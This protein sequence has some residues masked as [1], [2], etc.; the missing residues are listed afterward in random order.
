LICAVLATLCLALAPRQQT[1]PPNASV[2]PQT[3]PPEAKPGEKPQ[4][5]AEVRFEGN[6]R[7][8]EETLRLQIRTRA[9]GPYT[10][11]TVD[12]DLRLLASR[13]LMAAAARLE[14]LPDG[15]LRVVFTVKEIP[16]V[17]RIEFDGNHHVDEDDLRTALGLS[18]NNVPPAMPESGGLTLMVRKLEEK[19]QDEGYLYVEIS[20]EFV[21]RGDE[22][23]LVFHILEGPEVSV[24]HVDFIGLKDFAPRHVRSVMKTSR[25][26]WFFTQ[27][28]KPH[29]L[30]D[31]VVQIESFLRDEGY[32][33]ARVGVDAVTPSADGED[34]D[35]LIRI[36]QGERY[37]VHSVKFDGNKNF[38][39][40]ELRALI[41][42]KPGE[43][44]RQTVYRKD[45]E[46]LRKQYRHLGY[47]EV[48]IPQRAV[49][50]YVG[51]KPEVDVIFRI[52]EGDPKR[53]RDVRVV[54]NTK[55]KDEVV[56]R[57]LDLYP[58]D[59]F[60]GDEML[61]AEDRLR[62]TGFFADERGQP[63]AW[64]ENE[65]TDDPKTEDVQMRVEDGT[66]GVFSLYG[67]VSS[68]NG[69]F[70]GTD[71]SIE[72]FDLFDLPSSPGALLPE[73]L[74]QRAFHGAGQ[75]LHLRANP[76]STYSNYLI[77]FI[78]PY[79][80]GPIERPVF[81][82]TNF[83][84][85]EFDPRHYHEKTVGA[86]VS[87]GK[88]L[89]RETSV[90]MGV[91]NDRI[92]IS[93]VD[94][95][96]DLLDV[97]GGNS[98]RGLVGEYHWTRFDSLRNTTQGMRLGVNGEWLGGPFGAQYDLLKFSTSGELF[99]PVYENEEEQR[100]VLWFRGAFALADPYSRTDETPIF[101]RYF[102]G[103]PGSF[104]QL[105]GFESRGVGPHDGSLQEGGSAGWVVNTEYVF[106]LIETYDARL[107]E[108]T[109][110][111]RGV[112]FAD[113]GMLESDWNSL[114]DGKWRLSVGAGLRLKIPF[115]LLSAPLELYYGVPLQKS[116]EDERQSF[117][118]N[119]STRF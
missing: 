10:A 60:D 100:H 24:D 36:D 93:N 23:V 92:T 63:L 111:L 114:M 109:P 99:V 79:L 73:F 7:I 78:E 26:F 58:G 102:A 115:Q 98:V 55:T 20:P 1:A 3:P 113:Q 38:S 41:K 105:R 64:V 106:P 67:G 8:P 17:R 11:E 13:F 88:R 42:M 65:K 108:S 66:N 62:A 69:V 37:T 57:E 43:P 81:L 29:E 50:S 52:T 110:F 72:N 31:D 70:V 101:E 9:G 35:I 96:E 103:G 6:T 85:I 33:D 5:L 14:R 84:I 94:P 34:V 22:Y 77:D 21:R 44:Y 76:G 46:R 112:I 107:R 15:S 49:E 53:V 82:D 51:N 87:V 4:I 18:Q 19:Y 61:A 95:F 16:S 54:G 97:E 104:L 119:F 12:S 28:Y 90:S 48:E 27:T 68:G 47:I 25:S 116:N 30:E 89:S 86:I 71:L 39:E 91:R 2:A 32:L 74:D 83:H 59:L 117:Q 40:E 118:I 45:R 56:R 75:K 80:T